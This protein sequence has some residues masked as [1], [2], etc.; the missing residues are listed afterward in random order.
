MKQG[1]TLLELLMSVA[2]VAVLIGILVPSVSI[3]RARADATNCLGNLRSLGAALSSYLTEN[4]MTMPTLKAARTSKSEEVAVI[5][6]TLDAYVSSPRI[7]LC[8]SDRHEGMVTGTSYFWNSAL[9]GQP[10]ASLNFFSLFSDHTKIPVLVDKE[11]W[12][13]KTKDKVNHLFADG[14]ATNELRLF[15]E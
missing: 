5:D 2:V 15:S 12:H 3:V 14:H 1:F 8:P 4:Q 7:F 9:N 13:K 11:G 6:N 10:L